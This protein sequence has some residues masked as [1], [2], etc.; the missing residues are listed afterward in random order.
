[1]P[2]LDEK[3]SKGNST[4]APAPDLKEASIKRNATPAPMP[5][6]KEVSINNHTWMQSASLQENVPIK[7][8]SHGW[9]VNDF[10]CIAS[11]R[12][13]GWPVL[14]LYVTSSHRQAPSAVFSYLFA[15][16]QVQESW[17]VSSLAGIWTTDFWIGSKVT[18]RLAHPYII[19]TGQS[20]SLGLHC[21]HSGPSVSTGE[22]TW[23]DLGPG[24][25]VFGYHRP[26]G[27]CLYC[28]TAILVVWRQRRDS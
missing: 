13:G 21:V 26:V 9:S 25:P 14:S 7:W 16:G 23:A 8:D 4:S 2:D 19:I 6:L 1:M 3:N 18:S 15:R 11:A 17:N 27:I 12:D 24:R 28:H 20:L 5:Y 22:A 10:S